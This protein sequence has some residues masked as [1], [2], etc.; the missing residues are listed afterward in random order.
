MK[1]I[2]HILLIISIAAWGSGCSIYMAGK[3]PDKKNLDVLAKGMPRDTIIAE[4]GK[5]ISTVKNEA[6]NK[7][8]VYKFIQGYSKGAKIGRAVWHGTADVLTLGLWEVIGTP[9]ESVYNGDEVS[10]EITYDKN[11]CVDKAVQLKLESKE[12]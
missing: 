11:D 6:G 9:V 12:K 7:V 3:Q 5:P 2:I 8:D 4:L 1:R 10:Y